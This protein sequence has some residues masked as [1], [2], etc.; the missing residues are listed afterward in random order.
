MW[1]LDTEGN[2]LKVMDFLADDAHPLDLGPLAWDSASLSSLM[3]SSRGGLIALGPE[4]DKPK[5]VRAREAG[6]A[7]IGAPRR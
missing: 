3:V 5:R 1:L 7:V 2:K 6:H 4:R